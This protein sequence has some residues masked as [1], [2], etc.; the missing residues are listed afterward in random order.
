MQEKLCKGEVNTI[1]DSFNELWHKQIGHMS[2]KRFDILAKDELFPIKGTSL[3][4]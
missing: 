4:I 1:E 2:E 3:K